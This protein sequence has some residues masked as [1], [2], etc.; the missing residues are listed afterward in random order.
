MPAGSFTPNRTS[1]T[2][3]QALNQCPPA[4]CHVCGNCT[5]LQAENMKSLLKTD[6]LGALVG[7]GG[8]KAYAEEAQ[9]CS[10]RRHFS[11]L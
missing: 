8:A 5:A 6:E 11:S 7:L 2:L 9:L 10:S 4:L 3:M 1:F